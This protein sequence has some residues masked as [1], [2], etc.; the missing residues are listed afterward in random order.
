MSSAFLIDLSDLQYC[1]KYYLIL[2]G[3]GEMLVNEGWFN[4]S[5]G[6]FFKIK[7]GDLHS[8]TNSSSNR[9]EFITLRV[10]TE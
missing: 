4:V 7:Q 6:D 10:E 9:L 2:K 1:V 3:T 5:D 8:L